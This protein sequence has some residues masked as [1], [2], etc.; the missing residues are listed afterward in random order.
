MELMKFRTPKEIKVEEDTRVT[1][2]TRVHGSL[3]KK[4]E[5]AAAK[6]PQKLPLASLIEEVLIDYVAFLEKKGEL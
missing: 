2:S 5:T 4:L 1:V 6:T 3:R